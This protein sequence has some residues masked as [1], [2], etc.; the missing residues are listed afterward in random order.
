MYN[1]CQKVVRNSQVDMSYIFCEG[2]HQH[3]HKNPPFSS[4]I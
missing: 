3:T 1:S 4:L 2:Q